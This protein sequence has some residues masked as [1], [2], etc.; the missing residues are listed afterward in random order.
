MVGGK[1]QPQWFSALARPKTGDGEQRI[2]AVT[3]LSTVGQLGASRLSG[4]FRPLGSP[5]YSTTLPPAPSAVLAVGWV[6]A[7][8]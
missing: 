6:S 3:E 5:R 7:G 2:P 1:S 8:C 4:H